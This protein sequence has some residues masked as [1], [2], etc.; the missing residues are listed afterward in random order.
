M[1]NLPLVNRD[2]SWL[3]FNARVLQEATD[4]LNPLYERIRFL[5]IYSSNLAEYFA[6][7]V[8][9]H[10]NLLR[11]GKKEKKELHVETID[12][13]DQLIEKVILHQNEVSRNFD[14]EILPQL[15]EE[16]IHI[17]RRHDL[18]PD[19]RKEVEHYFHQ[20][21]LPYVQPVLLVKDMIRP[22]LNNAELYLI[23]AMRIKNK[24]PEKKKNRYA[25][26]KIPSD[27]LDRFIVLSHSKP[28][29]HDVI[30]LD[31]IV[32][33]CISCL[34]S[35]YNIEGTYSIKL[36]RDAE[37]YIDDEFSGD[38]IKKIKISLNQRNI[39]PASRLVY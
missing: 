37:L 30:F 17:L 22:F 28:G 1:K 2:I 29:H 8:S 36:T 25:I 7:R 33:H 31:D 15:N 21:M 18:N 12:I 26:V 13:L 11:L 3:E 38:L 27:H 24:N 32:R 16:N 34:F 19:Q 10:R 9:Q 6:V 14:D 23:V 39:G 35:G 5:A 4:P 20:Y